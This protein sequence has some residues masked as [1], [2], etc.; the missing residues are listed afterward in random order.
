MSHVVGIFSFLDTTKAAVRALKDKGIKD[1]TVHMPT[2][3]HSLA[4][5]I[6]DTPSPVRWITLAGGITGLVLAILM[7]GWMSAD[8]PVRVSMKPVLSWPPYTV[9]MF[10]MTVLIGGLSNLLALFAFAKLPGLKGKTFDP[11]F[12]DDKF[13]VVVPAAGRVDELTELLNQAGAE[14]IRHVD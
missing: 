12:T 7:T 5:E 13:G 2:Y 10:E 8:W 11:R 9:I 14:E 1:F 3:L 6:D 4:D